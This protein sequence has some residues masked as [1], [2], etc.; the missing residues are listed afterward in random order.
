MPPGLGRDS[1]FQMGKET[2]YGTYAT[3]TGSRLEIISEGLE[4]D[5]GVIDDPSLYAGVSRRGIYEGGK[6]YRGPLV[7]RGTFEGQLEI[8]RGIFGTYSNVLVETGVRD[9]TFKEGGT[10]ASYSF[11]LNKGNI[12]AT[13]VFRVLGAKFVPST[14]FRIGAGQGVEAMLQVESQI[15][16]KDMLAGQAIGASLTFPSVLPILFHSDQ[17]AGAIMDDGTADA[18]GVVRVRNVEVTYNQPHADDRFYMLSKNI[19]EPLRDDFAVAEWRIQQEFQTK[20]QFDLA[21]TWA[22][23][24]AEPSPKLII[25]HPTTIGAASK[26]EF[27]IRSN[28]CQIVGYSN[29]VAGPGVIIA[30]VTYRAFHDT[31]DVSALL[32]RVRNTEAALT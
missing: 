10:L 23:S 15:L 30:T 9:H 7:F 5:I 3:P 19:D 17:Q 31:T 25:Q 27:E 20:T 29:P 12:P 2:T 8:L 26:R 16:A 11:D 22:A 4:P 13:Q 18:V 14:T 6:L 21:R 24:G 28:K 1:W 32:V